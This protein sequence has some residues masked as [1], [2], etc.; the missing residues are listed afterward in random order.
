MLIDFAFFQNKLGYYRL[1]HI[2]FQNF[3]FLNVFFLNS[4]VKKM[5]FFSKTIF[6]HKPFVKED[7]PDRESY[8]IGCCFGP[9]EWTANHVAVSIMPNYL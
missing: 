1:F 5:Q 8:A 4:F 3:L 7:K 6:Y 9:N 2:L